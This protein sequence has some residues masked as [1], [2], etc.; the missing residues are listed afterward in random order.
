MKLRSDKGAVR[1][2]IENHNFLS[3]SFSL[4]DFRAQKAKTN[5]ASGWLKHIG[6]LGFPMHFLLWY[7][8]MVI[9]LWDLTILTIRS[10]KEMVLA[11]IFALVP[12]PKKSLTNDIA[13]VSG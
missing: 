4:K 13:L 8:M 5:L 2:G 12:R 6:K 7:Y 9:V 3:K 10:Y 11:I 1:Q